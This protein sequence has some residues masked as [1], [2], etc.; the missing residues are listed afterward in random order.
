MFA[1]IR[2]SS[3]A[4][5][6]AGLLAILP[7]HGPMVNAADSQRPFGQIESLAAYTPD[8]FRIPVRV[9]GHTFPGHVQYVGVPVPRDWDL[10]NLSVLGADGV[11]VPSASRVMARW[12]ETGN[13]RWLGVDFIADGG[14]D[15]T[16]VPASAM[17]T[18]AAEQVRVREHR[19]TF[20]VITGPARFL[21][22]RTGP[23]ISRAYFDRN[24]DGRFDE[25]ECILMPTT[26]S[27][28]YAIDQ[29]GVVAFAGNDDEAGQLVLETLT[30]ERAE[31]APL[32]RI[33]FRREGWY[34]TE[35]GDRVAR[36]ITRMHFRAGQPEVRF[37]HTFI[38][39]ESTEE[40]WFSEYGMHL[41]FAQA[42]RPDE[43]F[44]PM[45]EADDSD[46]LDVR[47]TG[48]TETLYLFQEK[49][50]Y[51]SR[52]DPEE[53]CHFEIGISRGR[54]SPD[55]LASGSLAGNWILAGNASLSA[56]LAVRNFW[57]T[58]PKELAVSRDRMTLQL[59]ASRGGEQLDF[60]PDVVRGRWP[61]EWYSTAAAGLKTR[62]ERM[63]TDALG[64]ARTHEWVLTLGGQ[65]EPV[66]MADSAARVQ[67]PPIALA[68]PVWLR[69]TEA[70]GRFHPYDP[71]RFADAEAFSQEWFDQHMYIWRQWGDYGFFEFG[72][73]PHVWYR[74]AND[75]PMEGRWYPYV[76]R[77]SAA[78]DY[79]TYA[80]LWRMFARSGD[81]QF[82][83]AAEEVTR[84]RLD[85]N[86]AHWTS[87][88]QA[89]TL[90]FDHYNRM[91]GRIRGTYS[92]S[93]SPVMWGGNY[94]AF[95]HASGTDIRALAYLY[96]LTDFRYA[97][98]MIGYYSDAV[99]RVLESDRFERLHGGR[100][101]AILKNLATVY[102]ETGDPEMKAIA[103]DQ[104][105]W[106]IDLDAPQ[107]VDRTKE[108]TGLAKYGVKAGALHRA[109]E[110]MGNPLAQ[111]ALVRG[112]TTRALN[113]IGE[114]PLGYYNVMGEQL[115]AAADL[116]G[117]P[118]FLRA[119]RRDMELAVSR[120]RDRESGEWT[121]MWSGVGPSA[122]A[123]I[124]PMGGIAFA[125]DVLARHEEATG[126]TVDLTPF[127]RQPGFGHPVWIFFEKPADMEIKLDIRSRHSLAPVVRDHSGQ[128]IENLPMSPY[129]D[130]MYSLEKAPTRW[131]VT[132][133]ATLPAGTYFIESGAGGHMW[134][135]T[136]TNAPGVVIHAPQSYLLGAGEGRQW[137]NRIMP[138]DTD[139]VVPVYFLVAED[140]ASFNLSNYSPLMLID[141]DGN[142]SRMETSGEKP[143]TI[144][145]PPA[146]RGA[147][148][149]IYPLEA[150]FIE[151][152]G[153]PPF[154]AYGDPERYFLPSHL[155]DTLGSPGPSV[156]RETLNIFEQD[157]L[158][159]SLPGM[160]GIPDRGLLLSG[161]RSLNIPAVQPKLI[162]PAEGTI[163]LWILP[164]WNS[165][166]TLRVSGGIRC[167]MDGGGWSLLLH[168]FG[169]MSATGIINAA[170][171]SPHRRALE[172]NAGVIFDRGQW[173]HL[174][175]QWR[176]HEDNF[177][178]EVYINGRKQIYGVGD[179]GMPGMADN[180]IPVE[181]AESLLI[182]N[183]RSGRQ[184]LDAVIGGLRFSNT[185][186]YDD[187]FD[188]ILADT[189]AVDAQTIALFRF[190]GDT[191]SISGDGS[192]RVEAT[193]N[194]P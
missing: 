173:T 170:P 113:A 106:L 76:D 61:D 124:Y 60:R 94:V 133:P 7:W 169:E 187:D 154:F 21:V 135:L 65:P 71:E 82:F 122:A 23:L 190:D 41:A 184:S 90:R 178:S 28:L 158:Y 174:A 72:N 134:E 194:N 52:M 87:P 31:G 175:W 123:N 78:M 177:I 66:A 77:Y 149:A 181:P 30:E 146:Q 111:K 11:P 3:A 119:L 176:K 186:R 114:P 68:D 163:E 12:P 168:R 141:P 137:G 46:I 18:A 127:A 148:W 95:H 58:F 152:S 44:V 110:V 91:R 117:D 193:V 109:H 99:K 14:T 48:A 35:A 180:F 185:A 73:W 107:G 188:P 112:S 26:G 67:H 120:Y 191:R 102:Q 39:T 161:R 143:H 49:A 6:V 2:I 142:R 62:L 131:E 33:V 139:H 98:E 179:A 4:I 84:Q 38:L 63:D 80:H 159:V 47:L 42:G 86:M 116:T 20:E 156:S 89:D 153:V 145:V 136:W 97:R 85:L 147:L 105:E 125:M 70:M 92:H 157:D 167:V 189:V 24:G 69:H 140:T 59:W 138:V 128:V 151:L 103:E 37:E 53:D 121:N 88:S 93:N 101:F 104:I 8:H 51:M 29:N 108:A 40:L 13:P 132:L 155:P 162:D 144:Q 1:R 22:P 55:I 54:G 9:T 75:G 130:Q 126:E 192:P 45:S 96:Y 165:I 115:A 182:G 150:G 57:Q 83:D 17:A 81:R 129:V 56:G 118:V 100:P 50:F 164:N 64:L 16:L 27:D 5:C 171:K 74:V 32:L 25:D 15:Y 160:R 172:S 36:H 10:R 183:N 19:D 79:G 34:V 166:P 43:A